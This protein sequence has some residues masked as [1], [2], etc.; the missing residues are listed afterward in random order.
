MAENIQ[1]RA[2]T[3]LSLDKALATQSYHGDTLPLAAGPCQVLL[4]AVDQ[5]AENAYLM[6]SIAREAKD[7]KGQEEDLEVILSSDHA[8]VLETA[9]QGSK[10]R[11]QSP[12]VDGAEIVFILPPELAANGQDEAFAD[13]IEQYCGLTRAD[14]AA[15]TTETRGRVELVDDDGNLLGTLDQSHQ[16]ISARDAEKGQD[17]ML[18]TVEDG[19][20]AADTTRGAAPQEKDW[21]INGAH[22]VARGLMGISGWAG[23]HIERTA[24]RLA[25]KVSVG[26]EAASESSAPYGAPAAAAADTYLNEKSGTGIDGSKYSS[27][28][29][30]SRYQTPPTPSSASCSKRNVNVHPSVSKGLQALSTGS[31]RVVGISHSARKKLLDAA[32]GTGRRLGGVRHNKDGTPKEP[33]MIRKQVQRGAQAVNVVLDGFDSAVGGLLQSA[34]ASTG[35][36]VGHHLG[37]QA[38]TAAGQVGSVGRNTWLVYKD[39]SG[40]RRR[41]ILKLAGGTLKGRTV[42]GQEITITAPTAPSPA[43]GI[44]RDS[45]EHDYVSGPRSGQATSSGAGMSASNTEKPPPSY[46]EDEKKR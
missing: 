33:G 13:V 12:D 18:V 43:S 10:Y 2:V 15:S 5:K 20:V 21:L 4:V 37:P 19:A 24:D 28:A 32:E 35:Q 45:I 42:D 30:S 38:R 9:T 39:V 44:D 34:G 22:Y 7:A 8:V 16:P 1:P 46:Y 3:L 26:N 14:G 31:G 27:D 17:A 36:V 41:V 6:L 11:I 23:G 29:R 25:P 40:V